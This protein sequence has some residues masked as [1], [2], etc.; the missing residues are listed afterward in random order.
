MGSEAS[1]VAG[2]VVVARVT[3]SPACAPVSI[4][5]PVYCGV[6]DPSKAEATSI[7]KWWPAYWLLNNFKIF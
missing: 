2:D 4:H 5:I 7:I 6:L 3:G 1:I